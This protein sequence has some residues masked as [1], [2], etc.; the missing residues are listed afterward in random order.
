MRYHQGI[1]NAAGDQELLERLVQEE[2]SKIA[3]SLSLI[4]EGRHEPEFNEPGK[5]AVAQLVYTDG[6]GWDP[7]GGAGYYYWTGTY[8]SKVVNN[9][10]TIVKAADTVRNN[11]ATVADDPHLQFP[12]V[13]NTVYSWEMFFEYTQAAASGL[14]FQWNVPASASAKGLT[15]EQGESLNLNTIHNGEQSTGA[16]ATAV[17]IGMYSTGVIVVAGT[18][19]T[20]AFQWA[21]GTA[22]AN[23]LTIHQN[24][25][26]RYT[27]LN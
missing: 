10:I 11:T 3:D 18:A 19:G 15:W 23:D 6:V 13:A 22:S 12:V 5:R 16:T 26:L 8:W 24:A 1:L 9:A 4:S 21:Q 25:W 7:G 27:R 20:A 14:D 2:L 17:R